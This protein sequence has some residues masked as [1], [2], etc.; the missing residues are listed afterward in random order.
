MQRLTNIIGTKQNHAGRTACD[1]NNTLHTTPEL[2]SPGQLPVETARCLWR[3]N[4]THNGVCQSP[5]TA[6][7]CREC[8]KAAAL[9][10][11]VKWHAGTMPGVP[12]STQTLAI[13]KL[14][15]LW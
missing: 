5:D 6:G 15:V 4:I 13:D 11:G 1:T 3:V 9:V 14:S 7:T 8:V 2:L 10:P 12:Q